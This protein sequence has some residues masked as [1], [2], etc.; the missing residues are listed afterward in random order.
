MDKSR[1][2]DGA[3]TSAGQERRRAARGKKRSPGFPRALAGLS[4]PRERLGAP[5]AC[6]SE[7]RGKSSSE[8]RVEEPSAWAG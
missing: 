3:G 6:P 8:E 1:Q 7:S 5:E 4:G 2:C